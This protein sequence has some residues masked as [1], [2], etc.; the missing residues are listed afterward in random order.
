VFAR[1]PHARAVKARVAPR[2]H[3]AKRAHY[4]KTA[5]R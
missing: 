4:V 3:R 5:N 1:A 2:G